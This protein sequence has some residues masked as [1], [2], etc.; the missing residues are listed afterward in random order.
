MASG[1]LHLAIGLAA[2]AGVAAIAHM[3]PEAT[4]LFAF[5]SAGAALLPDLDGPG[6]ATNAAGPLLAIPLAGFRKLCVRHRGVSHTLVAMLG[7]SFGVYELRLV[8]ATTAGS[9]T[10]A[11]WP[12]RVLLPALLTWLA[13]RGLLTLGSGNGT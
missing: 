4:G 5:T 7:L 10:F 1:H 11:Q 8:D 2:G 6:M 9:Q 12:L 13:A 3:T